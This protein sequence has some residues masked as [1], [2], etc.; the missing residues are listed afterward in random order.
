M[1]TFGQANG[2]RWRPL[3]AAALAWALAG[4]ACSGGGA[5][6]PA[7][8][9][10]T[11]IDRPATG[12]PAP[13]SPA[14]TATGGPVLAV[15]RSQFL[16]A[17]VVESS[18]S[19]G[20]GHDELAFTNSGPTRC[21]LHG[22]PAVSYVD[23]AGAQL[24]APADPLTVIAG[25]R[26]AGETSVIAPVILQPRGRAVFAL[27][28]YGLPHVNSPTCPGSP[29]IATAAHLRIDPPDNTVALLTP[30]PDSESNQVC[31]NVAVHALAVGAVT[32][33]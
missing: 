1:T 16:T 3:A 28:V 21:M 8:P 9:S 33:G 22:F 11:L 29:T 31:A 2:R 20:T 19:A 30:V 24:G 14:A 10:F 5:H 32:A 4:S 26:N 12:A 18:A 15:C 27:R 23:A 17:S 25:T 13:S 6:P 7:A